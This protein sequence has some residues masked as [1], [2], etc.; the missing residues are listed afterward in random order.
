VERRTRTRV[1]SVVVS[2]LV[3]LA[4]LEIGLR[5][6]LFRF[7][8]EDRLTK[9]ARFDDLPPE[10]YMYRGHAY[11]DYCLNESYRSRDGLN[12]HDRL[13]FRGREVEVDKA[14]GTYRIVCVG[15][16]TTYTTEVKDFRL[17][18][19]DQLERSLKER[20]GR[21]D[22]EVINA[23]VGGWSSYE[24]LIDVELRL[25]ALHPDL[26]VVYHGI[27]D[28][29]PRFVPPELYRRDNSGH[30]RPWNPDTRPWEHS[31]LLRCAAVRLGIA[32]PNTLQGLVH[33]EYPDIDL[34]ACLDAN[35]PTY[36]AD[37]LESTIAVAHHAGVQV[38]LAT[39]AFCDA[40]KQYVSLPAYQ[41]AIREANDVIRG[42]AARN[43]VPLLEFSSAMDPDPRLWADGVHVNAEGARVMADLFA[44]AI[45]KLVQVARK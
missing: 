41:R 17:S 27:N 33:I 16:S 21:A 39:F 43:D 5:I 8:D 28:C 24:C 4:A 38:L 18:Y 36:F 11:L 10:A 45:A 1:A 32:R 44:D 6:Y 26:L 35:P 9:Y 23:G 22:V 19:P 12:R 15:G 42:A 13:G 40:K 20:H 2:L 31:V 34:D 7:A 14:P 3:V 30:V 29:Y 37:N 25:L